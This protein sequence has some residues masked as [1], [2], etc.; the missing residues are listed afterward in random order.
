M[1]EQAARI[2]KEASAK[3]FAAREKRVKPAR[4]EKILTSWN[5]LMISAFAKGY[6]IS[7]DIRYL[8][9]AKN[10][11]EFIENKL[12]SYEGRLRRTFK[13]GQ[14]KLNAYLE[15]YAFYVNGREGRQLILY[16]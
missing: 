13:D 10:A 7:E 11:V 2:L 12:G 6:T 16:L 4:D 14:S 15:D 9:A 3:L 1:P 8:H 5:G